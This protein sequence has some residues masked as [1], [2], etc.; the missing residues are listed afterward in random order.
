MR[1]ESS[2]PCF[3][4]LK[5]GIGTPSNLPRPN[6]SPP[7]VRHRFMDQIGSFLAQNQADI[8]REARNCV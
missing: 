1:T 4:H 6:L 2:G 3:E 8:I 7:Q 5:I